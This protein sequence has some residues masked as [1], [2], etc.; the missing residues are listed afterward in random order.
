MA[1]QSELAM[2]DEMGIVVDTDP[3]EVNAGGGSQPFAAMGAEPAFE[4]TEPPM[5]QVEES[6]GELEQDSIDD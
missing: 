6:E 2:L 4:D 3:S 5:A 1:R